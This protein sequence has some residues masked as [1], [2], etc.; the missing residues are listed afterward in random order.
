MAVRNGDYERYKEMFPVGAQV[1][2][3]NEA[4]PGHWERGIV[5]IHEVNEHG[6]P[7]RMHIRSDEGELISFDYHWLDVEDPRNSLVRLVK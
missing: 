7:R 2:F 1:R 6:T 5:E 4:F 3:E